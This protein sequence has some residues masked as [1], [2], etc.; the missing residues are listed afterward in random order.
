MADT[1]WIDV[2][3]APEDRSYVFERKVKSVKALI[4]AAQ[5]TKKNGAP[6]LVAAG[7]TLTDDTVAGLRLDYAGQDAK[8]EVVFGG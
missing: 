4:G 1:V 8:V 3:K 6:E 5:V 7:S 2:T